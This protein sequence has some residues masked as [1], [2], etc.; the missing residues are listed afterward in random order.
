ME[1]TLFLRL[2]A[3]TSLLA[4]TAG[5][6][7]ADAEFARIASFATPLNNADP[8]AESSAEIIAA[9]GDGM[10]L[11]YTDSPLG[12]VGLIDIADPAAPRPLGTVDAGGSPTSVA[13][14]GQMAY[15]AV[16]TADSF[17]EPAGAL[18]VIDI[19]TR[20]EVARCDLG[21]QP[22]SSAVAPDGSFIAVAIENE[23]DED[24]GDGRVPQMPAGWVSLVPLAD[25]M[26]DCDGIIRAD[27]TGLAQIAPED[28]EPEFVDVNAAGETIVTLQE[29]NH[30]AIIARDGRVTAHFSAGAVDLTGID[31]TD[32][33]AALRFVEDQPGRLREPDAVKWIDA[34]RFAIA[35][36]GDMDGGARGWTVMDRTG[37]VV[38]ESGATLEHAIVQIGHYPDRRSDAKG[39]E[40]EGMGFATFG[41]TPVLALLTERASIMA[42]YDVTDPAAPVLT[43]LLPSGVSPEGVAMIPQRG[44]I[45]TAN[46]VDLGGD[47]LARA[48]VMIYAQG[49]ATYPTL[50]SAGADDLIGWG[51]L[52][53]LAAD[54]AQPGILY[55]VNDSFYGHQP[56]IFTIDATQTPARITAALDI[57]RA[58]GPAQKI[59]VEGIAVDPE[60][61]FWLA[62][63]GRTDRL[64]P[65]AILHVN[66]NGRIDREIAFPPELLAHEIR[67]GAEGIALVGNTLWLAMQ[68][69]WGDDPENTVKLVAYNL[70]TEE[71]G[72]VRY[73]LAAPAG[74]GWVGLSE[75]A[76]HGDHAWLIERDNQV[77]GNAAVKLVTRVPLAELV[78]APLGGDLPVV[79]RE[80]MRDLIPD[81]SAWGGFTAEKIEGMAI[82]A[83]GTAW[84]VTDNDGVDDSSGETLFWSVSLN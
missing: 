61:G 69:P 31:A 39:V 22:D 57:T 54:P 35:N 34:D 32:E 42:L 24:A 66:E 13:T 64:I 58:S 12:A 65:H 8:A 79:T 28:P 50:T 17:A 19:A 73:P 25:G 56:R 78:P 55:A 36:E 30:I 52:S 10:V 59:D 20:T 21:G 18:A 40:P 26:P 76:V 68:R 51:A 14:L 70:E 38:W 74:E 23:R 43:G 80:V 82:A 77:G 81:L 16:K 7:L 2:A 45:A 33:Q 72:A 83:D 44:L 9:S 29:N 3:T 63:E 1:S 4:L 71:W 75:I 67:F 49:A 48:H 11:I 6:A 15:V 60:G 84:I 5:A 27:L 46:E 62:N 37:A 47:G 41:D 53:G